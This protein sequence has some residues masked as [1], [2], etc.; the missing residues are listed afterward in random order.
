MCCMVGAT[1]STDHTVD[2]TCWVRL[3]QCRHCLQ[4]RYMQC[5]G[6]YTASSIDGKREGLTRVHN[7]F[8]FTTN[9][10]G[11]HACC[12]IL[13]FICTWCVETAVLV[14]C[15]QTHV[16]ILEHWGSM[17]YQLDKSCSQHQSIYT[18]CYSY[19][20][21]YQYLALYVIIPWARGVSVGQG[22]E[23]I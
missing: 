2:T 1:D 14:H 11:S 15:S 8:D 4:K 13:S 16:H 21:P 7:P 6:H 12:L 5:C 18:Q 17:K 22:M 10:C 20:W 19:R 3:R 23:V 9:N